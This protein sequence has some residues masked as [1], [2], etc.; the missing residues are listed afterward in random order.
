MSSYTVAP[1]P[2]TS[3]AATFAF[4]QLQS[5]PA[6]RAK[7]AIRNVF[8]CVESDL[9]EDIRRQAAE[10]F[11]DGGEIACFYP[12]ERRFMFVSHGGHGQLPNAD[13]A[14]TITASDKQGSMTIGMPVDIIYKDPDWV[15]RVLRSVSTSGL[16]D[17]PGLIS[18]RE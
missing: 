4:A 15:E 16:R 6:F 17:E 1:Q 8:V 2:E 12:G 9:M 13:T 10:L 11:P 18:V 7:Y 14:E 5:D 3:T